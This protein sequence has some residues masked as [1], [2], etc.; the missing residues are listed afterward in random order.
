[1]LLNKL[2]KLKLGLNSNLNALRSNFF[3]F[4]C[5]S[6]NN[7]GCVGRNKDVSSCFALF[8]EVRNN[9]PWKYTKISSTYTSMLTFLS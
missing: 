1:V 3:N 6:G 7:E 2:S 9:Q 8:R 4:Q 5:V